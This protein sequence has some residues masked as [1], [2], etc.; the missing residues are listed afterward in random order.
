VCTTTT[1]RQHSTPARTGRSPT[2]SRSSKNSRTKAQ[3]QR[4]ASTHWDERQSRPVVAMWLLHICHQ[5]LPRPT[6]RRRKQCHSADGSV[7]LTHPPR[8]PL[9]RRAQPCLE[10]S[11]FPGHPPLS[12]TRRQANTR[13][14]YRRGT[15][16]RY[17]PS[18]E[19]NLPHRVLVSSG[20][21]GRDSRQANLTVPR[22]NVR[23]PHSTH[24]VE[25][26]A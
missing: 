17:P 24:K 8:N 4:N 10:A 14:T 21:P 11:L 16:T 12:P 6:P 22:Q 9:P 20:N 2:G 7:V 25:K 18:L 1:H 26:T 5:T 19:S 15:V 23:G 13:P 3:R